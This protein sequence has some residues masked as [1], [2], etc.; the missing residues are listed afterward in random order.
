MLRK[1]Y[2]L[3]YTIYALST[4]S[5]VIEFK[6]LDIEQFIVGFINGAFDT[7]YDKQIEGDGTC[8][9]NIDDITASVNAV[10]KLLDTIDIGALWDAYTA[11]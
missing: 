11:Y 4:V 1:A 6:N 10:F 9:L 7:T 2:K 5:L 8:L 3:L